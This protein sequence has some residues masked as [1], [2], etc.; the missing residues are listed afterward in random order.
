MKAASGGLMPSMSPQ[1][2]SSTCSAKI[3]SAAAM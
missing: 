1:T 3:A 2:K